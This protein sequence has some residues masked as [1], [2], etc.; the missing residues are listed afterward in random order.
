MPAIQDW[1]E[2]QFAPVLLDKQAVTRLLGEQYP[3]AYEASNHL[4]R[5][6]KSTMI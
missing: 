1:K 4:T 2:L 3:A 5:T 6:I